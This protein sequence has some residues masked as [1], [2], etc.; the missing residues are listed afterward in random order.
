[1]EHF[2]DLGYMER[3][4]EV[5]SVIRGQVRH[6]AAPGAPL[7]GINGVPLTG[8]AGHLH[9]HAPRS[10]GHLVHPGD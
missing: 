10:A 3:V 5:I 7:P 6:T 4:E 1:M 2:R 9:P 8:S